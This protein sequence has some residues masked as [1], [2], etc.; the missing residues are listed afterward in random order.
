MVDGDRLKLA[1]FGWA[2]YAK[3][4]PRSTVCGTLDYFPNEMVL[5]DKRGYTKAIDLWAVGVLAYE[6]RN[7]RAPF[8][9]STDGQTKK[10]IKRI[11]YKVPKRFSPELK[12]FL[13]K[14]ICKVED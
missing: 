9:S 3:E 14:L 6:L 1:D 2:V 13:S 12:D 4:N 10:K 7:G 5:R 11:E 8:A